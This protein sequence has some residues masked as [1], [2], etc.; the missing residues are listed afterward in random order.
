MSRKLT[1]EE[2]IEKAR[3]VHG[4]FYDYSE[5]KYVNTHTKVKIICPEH[6]P[7]FQTPNDHLRN[8]GCKL[9]AIKH[10]SENLRK[11]LVEFTTQAQL[12]H[13][14]K[15]DYSKVIYTGAHTKVEIICPEHGSFFQT[16][17][18]H[19]DGHGCPFCLNNKK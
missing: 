5:V 13:Q 7:F 11:D 6:G 14:N 18:N 9:C 19:I 2:F 17:K 1:T 3:K 12:A 16:P 10:N 4:D 8:H 15:Y